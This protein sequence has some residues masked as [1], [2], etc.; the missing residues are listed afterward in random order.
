MICLFCFY[1]TERTASNIFSK[2]GWTTS[3]GS[4]RRRTT[5]RRFLSI[6][7][8]CSFTET[9]G[10]ES[11]RTQS[12]TQDRATQ[13]S[14]S[15]HVTASQ[16]LTYSRTSLASKPVNNYSSIT[17]TDN[18]TNDGGDDDTDTDTNNTGNMTD[19]KNPTSLVEEKQQSEH[20][21]PVSPT[22][23]E[24]DP[25]G[26]HLQTMLQKDT[27]R[28]DDNNNDHDGGGVD[29]Q[30]TTTPSLDSEQV[31]YIGHNHFPN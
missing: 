4:K 10:Q 19:Q 1:P 8:C 28:H 9:T 5:G 26:Q 7:T 18:K 15:H 25:I 20:I 22:G 12:S 11:S 23:Q 3:K 2:M 29:Y 16:T 14:S 27:F 24:R 6:L 31:I 21:I 30:E 17:T 13:R